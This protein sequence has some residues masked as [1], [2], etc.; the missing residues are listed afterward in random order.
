MCPVGEGHCPDTRGRAKGTV[1]RFAAWP[2]F[3]QQGKESIADCASA[4]GAQER[5][6]TS[7]ASCGVTS[8][9]SC[10]VGLGQQGELQVPR[11]PRD[12]AMGWVSTT[13]ARS[14]VLVGAFFYVLCLPG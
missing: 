8:M 4:E 14:V 7:T 10:L 13:C 11:F 3:F 6:L 12:F 9:S 1:L 2:L 5:S